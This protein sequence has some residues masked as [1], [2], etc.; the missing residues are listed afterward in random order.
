MNVTA[1]CMRVGR[2]V[3]MVNGGKSWWD[4]QLGSGGQYVGGDSWRVRMI[5]VWCHG[6]VRTSGGI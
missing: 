2:L 6:W 1:A 5:C 3:R 4:G